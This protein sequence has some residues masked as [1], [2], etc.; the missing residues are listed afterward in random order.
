MS[1]ERKGIIKFAGQDVTLVGADLRVGQKAP[2]FTVHANDWSVVKA[3]ESTRG[4]VR[5]IGSLPSLSTSV[6]DRET[7]RFNIEAASLGEDIVVLLVSMDIPWTQK[8]WCAAAGVEKVIT[9]SDHMT[10]EFGEKYGVLI[11][12]QRIHRRS[13]FVVD[14]NNF[15]TYAAYMATLGEEP[16]YEAVLAAAKAA[17][18]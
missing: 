8:E 6:C 9:L 2:E 13:I 14:R 4:K 5:I 16:Q 10:A 18:A 15:I 12:E 17:L 3:L 1:I 11:K 7:R